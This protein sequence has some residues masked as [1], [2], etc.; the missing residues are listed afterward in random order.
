[1]QKKIIVSPIVRKKINK[2]IRDTQ[3]Y[4]DYSN[5]SNKNARSPVKRAFIRRTKLNHSKTEKSS[6]HFPEINKLSSS[7]FF[8]KYLDNKA[9]SRRKN[10]STVKKRDISL[11]SKEQASGYNIRKKT[12]E[13]RQSFG[14]KTNKN[15]VSKLNMSFGNNKTFCRVA[16]I[17]N[18][19]PSTKIDRI[20][21]LTNMNLKLS[22]ENKMIFENLKNLNTEIKKSSKKLIHLNYR[23]KMVQKVKE[24]NFFINVNRG[25]QDENDPYRESENSEY[26]LTK[27]VWH[28]ADFRTPAEKNKQRNLI[29]E[30]V[31]N[32]FK[33]FQN[34]RKSKSRG[35][36]VLKN[37]ACLEE[38]INSEPKNPSKEIVNAS[39]DSF[40]N[41]EFVRIKTPAQEPN[42]YQQSSNDITS[43]LDE[44][45]MVQSDECMPPGLTFTPDVIVSDYSQEIEGIKDHSNPIFM[46]HQKKKSRGCSLAHLD[47][48]C[49]D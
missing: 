24:K 8:K 48:P 18:R 5:F 7:G 17:K 47:T 43:V 3:D 6:S 49:F 27:A 41:P 35:K 14:Y 34:I 36:A 37:R 13:V 19:C 23:P 22:I 39:I 4:V 11:D 38:M 1:M 9:K 16:R 30:I 29:D 26:L 20:N 12:P 15:I 44:D 40:G 25:Y 2:S 46:P 10:R 33:E 32:G 45:I 21:V 28:G 42:Y 31:R